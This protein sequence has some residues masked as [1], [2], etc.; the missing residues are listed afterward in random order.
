MTRATSALIRRAAIAPPRRHNAMRAL[1]GIAALLLS[2]STAPAADKP[3]EIGVLALG[4]RNEPVWGCKPGERSGNGVSHETMPFYV[5][6]M[7]DELDKLSYA[8]IRAENADRARRRFNLD[9]RLGTLAEL[10]SAAHD[11]IRKPVDIIVAV[12]TAGV[13]VAQEETRDHPIPIL[14]PGISDPVADG[15]VA[16]LARPGGW[17]TG[18]SHQQVQASGKRVE[19][20]KEI[21]PGLQRLITIRKA[22]YGPSEKSMPEIRATAGRLGVE[23]LDWS[24]NSRDELKA[25]LAA[26]EHGASA[27]ILMLPDSFAISSLDLIV[28]ASLE[29]GVPIFGQQDYMADWGAVAAYGPST[30]QAGGRVAHYIDKIVKGAKP[31]DL[32]VEPVDPVSVVNLKAARC[33]GISIPPDVLHQADRVIQ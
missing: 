13:R 23:V 4:P 19:M 18:V 28:P 21:L 7:L 33:L 20:F 14:F 2:A 27:G 25:K 1:A 29:R 31:G 6:G 5:R 30:Y 24:L 17:I 32:P 15:F 26:L 9:M 11:F 12:A 8:D 3:L 22:G 16:S 10:R